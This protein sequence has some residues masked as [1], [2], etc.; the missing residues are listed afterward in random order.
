MDIK[1]RNEYSL[2]VGW[3]IPELSPSKKLH[4]VGFPKFQSHGLDHHIQRHVHHVPHHIQ[5]HIQRHI[6]RSQRRDQLRNLLVGGFNPYE[7]YESQLG[8]WFPIYVWKQKF[9]TTNLVVICDNK[10]VISLNPLTYLGTRKTICACVA[11][12]GD[13]DVNLNMHGTVFC[14]FW[15]GMGWSVAKTFMSTWTRP[16]FL[17]YMLHLGTICVAWSPDWSTAFVWHLE[18]EFQQGLAP[19]DSQIEKWNVL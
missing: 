11:R 12:A 15:L 8:W 4:F 10:G 9:Q 13:M 7:R 18:V 1:W 17:S 3:V 6:R 14:A 5:R 2:Y 19:R 16:G